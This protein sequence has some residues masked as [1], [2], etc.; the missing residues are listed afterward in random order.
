[1]E[2]L[3]F[4][5]RG[6]II[7]AASICLIIWRVRAIHKAPRPIQ[8]SFHQQP[9]ASPAQNKLGT[10]GKKTIINAKQFSELVKPFG[11]Q[12]H[13]LSDWFPQH[14]LQQFSLTQA[15]QD[16]SN[17]RKK[18]LAARPANADFILFYWPLTAVKSP[19]RR[20]AQSKENNQQ[21]DQSVIVIRSYRL[22]TSPDPIKIYSQSM[23][24][25]AEAY[26][27]TLILYRDD[28][29]NNLQ[30]LTLLI[31]DALSIFE[32]IALHCNYEERRRWHD[33]ITP[34]G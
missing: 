33:L 21:K 8:Q 14:L 32:S 2:P 27:D 18:L 28:C 16:L 25:T 9:S 29:S 15:R 1:M 34:A 3:D 4:Y 7:L 23:D 22:E 30:A 17:Q 11:L 10:E 5:I 12:V 19:L 26:S 20:K 13:P 31:E 24:T 6:T